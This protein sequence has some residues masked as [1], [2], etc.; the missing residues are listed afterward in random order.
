MNGNEN[1]LRKRDESSKT[2]MSKTLMSRSQ[3]IK[4]SI[5][6]DVA[7][8]I[9]PPLCLYL[10]A[11]GH[12]FTP[13]SQPFLPM[14]KFRPSN[15]VLFPPCGPGESVYQTLEIANTSDTPVYYK[16]YDDSSG[17][18]KV[19]PAQGLINGKSFGLI[20]FEFSPPSA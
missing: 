10:R 15:M 3:S 4:K 18:F 1:R 12:S 2:K 13:D 5:Y 16:M 7:D 19:Y 8:D 14:V 20:S 11:V 6:D 9:E 17:V